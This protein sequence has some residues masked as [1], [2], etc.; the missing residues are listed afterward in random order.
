LQTSIRLIGD[1][2]Y[3]IKL[4][5]FKNCVALGKELHGDRTVFQQIITHPL[6]RMGGSSANAAIA[7][8][9]G[10]EKTNKAEKINIQIGRQ[11]WA[12]GASGSYNIELT[13]GLCAPPSILRR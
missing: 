6:S 2:P 7:E 11:D 13:F 8:T 12:F 9:K 5:Y 10:C 4:P 3:S 1:L